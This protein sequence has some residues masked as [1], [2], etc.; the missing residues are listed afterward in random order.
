MTPALSQIATSDGNS[1]LCAVATH[2]GDEEMAE[3]E[4]TDC[5][6]HPGKSR[7]ESRKYQS[8]RLAA[9]IARSQ[10]GCERPRAVRSWFLSK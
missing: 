6:N 10:S 8:A 9:Q 2:E 5:V 4:V 7:Q 3:T 1:E